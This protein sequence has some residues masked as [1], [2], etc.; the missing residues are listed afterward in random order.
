[1]KCDKT[2]QEQEAKAVIIQVY[3]IY[4]L[5]WLY[6]VYVFR[7]FFRNNNVY[8]RWIDVSV[9]YILSKSFFD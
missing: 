6:M 2:L 4:H 8:I 9:F 1:M 3:Y 5:H 7:K